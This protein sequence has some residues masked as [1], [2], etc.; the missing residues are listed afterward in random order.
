MDKDIQK[1]RKFLF[2]IILANGS[3]DLFQVS[4]ELQRNYWLGRDMYIGR[5][6]CHGVSLSLL[7]RVAMLNR[8]A[9]PHLPDEETDG[10]CV[11]HVVYPHVPPSLM[12][13]VVPI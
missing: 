3:Q 8:V 1:R 11:V 13:G 7:G 5:A 12:V 6:C 4:T 2:R 9:I 10:G